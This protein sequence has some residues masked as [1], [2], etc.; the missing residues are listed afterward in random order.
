MLYTDSA[1]FL[2]ETTKL[3][4]NM[5]KFMKQSYNYVNV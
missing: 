5:E 4:I 2:Y 1:Y 3:K